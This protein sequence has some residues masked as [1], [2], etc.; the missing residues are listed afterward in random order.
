VSRSEW[1]I[2]RC[3]GEHQREAPRRFTSSYVAKIS[4]ICSRLTPFGEAGDAALPSFPICIK[5]V[6]GKLHHD[7]SLATRR[8]EGALVFDDILL[9]NIS[10]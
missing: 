8:S 1:E 5:I 7:A 3:S 9:L 4:K 10:T 2:S 6:D